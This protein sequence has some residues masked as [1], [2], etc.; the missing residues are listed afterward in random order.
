MWHLSYARIAEE[1][2][3]AA[4]AEAAYDALVA[5]LPSPAGRRHPLRQVIGELFIRIG[6]RLVMPST[7]STVR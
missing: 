7:P 2:V 1:Q 4:R 3:A 5:Q 6:A